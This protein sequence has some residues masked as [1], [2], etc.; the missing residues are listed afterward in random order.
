MIVPPPATDSPPDVLLSQLN[1]R[2]V[3]ADVRDRLDV[4]VV[5][6]LRLDV[7]SRHLVTVLTESVPRVP[8]VHHRVPLGRGLAGRVGELGAAIVLDDVAEDD[9]VNPVLLDLGV[10]SVLAVPIWNGDRLTGVLKVGSRERRSFHPDDVART[11]GLATAVSEAL[12]EYYAAD[13]RAAAAALQRS[14]VPSS[15]PVIDGLDLAGRYVPGQGEVSGD[16][17]DVFSL[18]GDRVGIAMGDVAGHGLPASVVMGRLRSA[19]RAYSLEYDEPSE[20]LSHL[21]AK[22]MHFE[23]GA[24]ATAV[25]AVTEPPYDA[26]RVSSAG[27]LLPVLLAPDGTAEQVDLPVSLPLGVDPDSER[28]SGTVHLDPGSVLVLFTDGLVERRSTSTPRSREVFRTFESALDE[29]CRNLRSD[30]ADAIASRVL[31]SML[32]IEPPADDVAVLVVARPREE[33]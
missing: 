23:P 27:H 6:V 7:A 15:L 29:L 14:L 10:H 2:E 5:T 28:V 20:V 25:Y 9:L 19:L 21:D 4:D 12:E 32:T 22:I 17:Y 18:P 30:G 16:W 3:L 13:E 31:D 26:V 8:P 1:L 24:M 11:Q 33:T